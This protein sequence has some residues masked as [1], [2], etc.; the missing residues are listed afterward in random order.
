[1]RLARLAPAVALSLFAG[2]STL[3][4]A[5]AQAANP[6]Q[7]A[8]PAQT[9]TPGSDSL[10][11]QPQEILGNLG[12]VTVGAFGYDVVPDAVLPSGHTGKAVM[13]WNPCRPIRWAINT[14]HAPK[15]FVAEARRAVT[16]LAHAT[17]FRM[18]FAGT[19]A[20]RPQAVN[21]TL[22]DGPLKAA[23]LQLVIAWDTKG[24]SNSMLRL[25]GDAAGETLRQVA[26]SGGRGSASPSQYDVAAIALNRGQR[27]QMVR[28]NKRGNGLYHVLL[29]ELGH[30]VGLNHVSDSHEIMAPMA[31][32]RSPVHYTAGDR[33]GLRQVGSGNG[34]L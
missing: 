34:C 17:G 18:V 33:L 7:A 9:T 19:T 31:A 11:P 8:T 14:D 4:A 24:D 13:R 23:G 2:T 12:Q 10:A 28:N 21:G 5:P 6:A 27:K 25:G 20:P 1:M 26:S 30:S 16:E 22:I 15:G 3:T 32:P 29:H